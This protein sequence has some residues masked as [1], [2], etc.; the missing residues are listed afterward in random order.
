LEFLGVKIVIADTKEKRSSL[1]E[2][3][4]HFRKCGVIALVIK[5]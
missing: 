5:V 3:T 2:K 1:K 4:P